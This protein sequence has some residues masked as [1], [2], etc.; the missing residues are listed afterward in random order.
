MRCYVSDDLTAKDEEWAGCHE[1][2]E[3]FPATPRACDCEG[4]TSLLKDKKVLAATAKVTLSAGGPISFMSGYH[5]TVTQVVTVSATSWETAEGPPVITVPPTQRPAPGTGSQT[6]LSTGAEIGVAVGASVAGLLVLGL[7][8]AHILLR[9][10][11]KEA[12]QRT[13]PAAPKGDEERGGMETGANSH[14]LEGG[15]VRWV[16]LI[17]MMRTCTNEF[18]PIS[19]AEH[20]DDD[21]EF[22]TS[23]HGRDS[24]QY[25]RGSNSGHC[26]YPSDFHNHRLSTISEHSTTLDPQPPGSSKGPVPPPQAA[27]DSSEDSTRVRVPGKECPVGRQIHELPG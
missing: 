24:N 18:P 22:H 11:K 27:V 20:D 23:Q 15:F 4:K 19:H 3:A 25:L 10:R 8:L 7:V 5:P 13:A 2:R 9:I 21:D 12:G 16:C 17:V 14:H 1:D 26:R 6:P